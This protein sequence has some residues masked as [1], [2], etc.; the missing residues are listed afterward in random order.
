MTEANIREILNLVSQ[1]R[2]S[3]PQGLARRSTPSPCWAALHLL[4]VTQAEHTGAG[5]AQGES[6]VVDGGR[7]ELEGNSVVVESWKPDIEIEGSIKE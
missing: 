2:L 7:I 1:G 6:A 3:V 4:V 5:R